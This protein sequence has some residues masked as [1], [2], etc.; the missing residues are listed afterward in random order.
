[1][2]KTFQYKA[3]INQ[4][5]AKKAESW[6]LLCQQLYNLCLEQRIMVYRQHKV[7]L[8]QYD[9]D[10]DLPTLKEAFPEFKEVGSQVLQ[11]VTKR[12]NKAFVGFFRRIK[13]KQGKA[14]F[15]RFKSRNRYDSFTLKQK[16]I[17]T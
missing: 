4:S 10:K 9:Q 14:G 5:T 2:K 1:M 12:V 3:V 8:S 15:P 16:R 6:L 17:T 7:T 11:D 13:S